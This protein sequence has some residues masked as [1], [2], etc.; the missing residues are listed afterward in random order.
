MRDSTMRKPMQTI[1]YL[2]RDRDTKGCDFL[3]WGD[4]DFSAAVTTLHECL[5][6]GLDVELAAMPD[7]ALDDLTRE[8]IKG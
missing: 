5:N 1:L 8:L 2:V 4:D 3:M 6:D 7:D